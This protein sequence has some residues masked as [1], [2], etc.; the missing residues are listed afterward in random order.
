M[1][2]RVEGG[3]HTNF[4]LPLNKHRAVELHDGL[5]FQV[6]DEIF[7]V[8]GGTLYVGYWDKRYDPDAECMMPVINWTGEKIRI[9]ELNDRVEKRRN[10]KA[11]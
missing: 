2:I 11:D 1:I 5:I 4:G 9:E 7:E 3:N 6:D 8:H 10:S